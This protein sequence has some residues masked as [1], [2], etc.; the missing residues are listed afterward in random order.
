MGFSE[1]ELRSIIQQT[2]E[3]I[4]GGNAGGGQDCL[5]DDM[6]D[7]IAAAKQAQTKLMMMSLEERGRL[8]EAIR[9][10]A[11]DNAEYLARMANEETGYGRVEDKIKKNILTAQKTPGIEDLQTEAFSGDDGLT[12]VELAPYGVIGA[13]TPSTN[14][15]STVVNNSMSMIAAGNA[16]VFCPH[17]SA[18]R[19]SQEAMK[20]VNKAII[21]AGGPANL[22]TGAKEPT[23]E[24]SNVVMTHPDIKMLAVTGGE[25]IVK[26]AMKSGK[27]AVCAGPGNPPVMVDETADI[28]KAGKDIVDG[29]SL[30]N[31][32]M[33][34]EEKECFAVA[35]ICDQLMEE[36][37]K[38]GA[39]RIYGDDIEKVKNTTLM[40][41]DGK[42][43]IN[44]KFVG[45]NAG[46][47][48]SAAGVSYVGDPRLVICEVDKDHPFIH[49]EMMMPVLGIVRVADFEE[50]LAEAYRAERGCW[51]SAM[52][53]STNVVRLSKAAKVMGTTIFVKNGPSY[54]GLGLSGEGFSTLTIATPTGEGLTSARSFARKRR[55]VLKGDFRIV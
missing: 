51:H 29:A 8:V 24:N 32:V 6:N 25:G 20:I 17:P 38:N 9:A 45:R 49:T 27:K 28:R 36:M 14:P 31:N 23:I 1:Q 10:A 44:R 18:K 2:V 50:C 22:I 34:F 33:C 11:I 46:Y 30:D 16:V 5:F 52:I 21:A 48:L 26:V 4:I 43:V 35:S 7:A 41:K 3:S 12:L 53:H 37:Q 40:Q 42:W 54:A 19:C 39:I 15:T 55:C 13:V 47:I